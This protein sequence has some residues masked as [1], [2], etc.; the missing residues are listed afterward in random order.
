MT[1]YSRPEQE[2][3]L[4]VQVGV[5]Y[6]SDLEQVERVTS[7]VVSEVMTE[8][9]GAVPE[10]EPAIRFHTFGDSRIS[11]TVILGVGEFSDQYRIKHEFIKRLHTRYRVEGIRIPSPARTIALQQ[12][13]AAAIPQQWDGV[14][15]VS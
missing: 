1:N 2:M 10:H 11:F 15:S 4:T 5:G 14:T 8:I 13:G 3:T 9:E 12:N 7:E 6:D